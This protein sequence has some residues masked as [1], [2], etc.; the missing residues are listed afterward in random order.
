[1]FLVLMFWLFLEERDFIP[2]V[3]STAVYVLLLYV[4][5]EQKRESL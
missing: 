4:S 5:A 1:M 3:F 2:G